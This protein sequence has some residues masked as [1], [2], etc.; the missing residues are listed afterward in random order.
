MPTTYDKLMAI[1]VADVPFSYGD[2]ETML[3]AISVGMGRDPM[4]TRELDYVFE[5]GTLR[6]VPSQACVIART[7]LL[8]DAGL[9]RTKVLHGEQWLTMH[10]PLPP[11]ADMLA[12]SCVTD[13]FDKGPGKGAVIYVETKV[14]DAATGEPLFTL[15]GSTF[16]RGDGGIG[17]PGGSAPAPHALPDRKPDLVVTSETRADQALL[18]RLNGD[19]NPLHADPQLALRAG[20]KMP[21][22]HGLCTYGIACKEIVARVCDYDH[23]AL[24]SLGVR[25]SSPVFPGETV[26]TD[27]WMDGNIVSFRCRI[28]ARDVVAVNNGR[29]ELRA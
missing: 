23:T 16:A 14:R 8:K 28:P 13:A 25:F 1:R 15:L 3:Y 10:R 24:K 21:I 12:D 22:L 11:A 2:R 29:A 19:R 17:G 9:D 7:Q 6:T 26:A 4:D 27:I 18:Y 20:F 5:G